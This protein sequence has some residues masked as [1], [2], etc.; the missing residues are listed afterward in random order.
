MPGRVL[1]G[2]KRV[3]ANVVK[4]ERGK[5][6]GAYLAGRQARGKKAQ[7]SLTFVDD[8]IIRGL[9]RKYRKIDRA[10]DVLSFEMG[11]EGMLGDVVISL[12]TARRN[13]KRFKV[14]LDDEIKRLVAHGALH[15]LGY[16][17]ETR[18]GR[19]EMRKKEQIYLR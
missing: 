9:N 10:T 5:G 17:H 2:V 19:C 1:L 3:I 12:D 18:D 16:D 13:A 4:S 11:E 8:K 15:L 7:V 14:S 6:Q